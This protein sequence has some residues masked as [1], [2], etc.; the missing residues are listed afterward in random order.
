MR[1]IIFI[2]A[3]LSFAS[4][5]LIAQQNILYK[6]IAEHKSGNF[7]K[8]HVLIEEASKHPETSQDSKTWYYKGLINKDLYKSK[9]TSN[10]YSETRITAISAY[11]QCLSLD[12]KGEYKED[13][14]KAITYLSSTV[15]NDA[16]KEM[17]K[18]NYKT[19]FVN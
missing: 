5:S 3:L 15:Y 12:S 16:A 13:C 19:A 9:E 8:A 14:R 6:A 11:I 10:S 18:E 2:L 4:G 1:G 7:E 17:N